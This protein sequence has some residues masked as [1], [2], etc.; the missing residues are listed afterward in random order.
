[1]KRV[2][3]YD[4]KYLKGDKKENRY[5]CANLDH[6]NNVCLAK[7]TGGKNPTVFP[8][9]SR[10]CACYKEKVEKKD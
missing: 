4:A 9:K 6:D 2:R 10:S 5:N 3:C 8:S 7:K 1:M